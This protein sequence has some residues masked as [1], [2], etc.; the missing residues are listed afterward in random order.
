MSDVTG[1]LLE[2]FARIAA[3]ADAGEPVDV[4]EELRSLPVV[5]RAALA[6]AV[7]AAADRPFSGVTV[8]TAGGFSRGTAYRNNRGALHTVTAAVPHVVDAMLARAREGA[9]SAS[10]G[11][12]VQQRDDT[13]AD[14]RAA[15]RE[16]AQERDVAIA[17]ARD[18]HE[19]L[20]PEF[21]AILADK[22]A[23]VRRLRAIDDTAGGVNPA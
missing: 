1:D 12:T 19:Q 8:A 7:L 22:T 10:L 5:L 11:A 23:K 20:A 4:A 18:L 16:T 6:V 15:L 21:R 3:Q 9:T 17:Y 14:L 13:I 2:T